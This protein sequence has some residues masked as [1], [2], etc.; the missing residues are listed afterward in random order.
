MSDLWLCVDVLD[1]TTR[2]IVNAD[3]ISIKEGESS[4]FRR[5]LMTIIG[6][7]TRTHVHCVDASMFKS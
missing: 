3:D 6:E 1:A 5:H 7:I 4:S 2:K